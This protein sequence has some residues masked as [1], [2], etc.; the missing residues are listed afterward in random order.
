MSTYFHVCPIPLGDG[1]IIKAGNFGRCVTQYRPRELGYNSTRE[2]AFEVVRLSAFPSRPS[3]LTSIFLFPT[4]AHASIYRFQN[5]YT[6]VIYEVEL[7]DDAPIFNADISLITSPVPNELSP[8]IPHIMALAH[9]YWTGLDS[10]TATSELL[11]TSPVRIVATHNAP[12]YAL[13]E[14]PSNGS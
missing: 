4:L 7:I 13:P 10:I 14:P 8:A 3:R 5:T 9:Q 12:A 2:M 11:T 6:S 1:A